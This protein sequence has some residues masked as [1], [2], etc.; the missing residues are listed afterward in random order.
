MDNS[1]IKLKSYG[2]GITTNAIYSYIIGWGDKGTYATNQ[3]IADLLEVNVR[4][5]TR[6]LRELNEKGYIKIINPNKK[7]RQLHK[8]HN[9]PH[10][11]H[12]DHQS[13]TSCPSRETKC[14]SLEDTVSIYKI[15]NIDNNIDDNIS[16]NIEIQKEK[17]EIK[18]YW[19]LVSGLM[20]QENISQDE[21]VKLIKENY[22]II[23]YEQTF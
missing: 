11:G 15:D 1:F 8:G 6:S 23:E 9:V 10:H 3:Q 19:E 22:E 2:L 21:A 16:N 5:V 20:L 12:S 17:I 18:D 13:G 7:S 4:T 14:P